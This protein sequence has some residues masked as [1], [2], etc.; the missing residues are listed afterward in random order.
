MFFPKEMTEVELIIPSKDLVAV[1]KVLSGRG[2]FHQLDSTYLGMENVGPTAWQDKA[3][4][5]STL[6]RRIQGMMQTLNLA[7]TYPAKAEADSLVE[8]DVI[9]PAVDR[10]DEDVKGTGDQLISEKKRLE[11]LE[12]QLRQLEPISHINY[13]VGTLRNSSF[14]HS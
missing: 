10:I 8:L 5:Y 2:V 7:E 9:R 13:E 1:A 12:S 11:L 3:G 14:L 4:N 6:E